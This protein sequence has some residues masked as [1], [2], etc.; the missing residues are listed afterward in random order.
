[1]RRVRR[2]P[3]RR[4]TT[5]Q[6]RNNSG[7][8]LSRPEVCNAHPRGRMSLGRRPPAPAARKRVRGASR[9]VFHYFGATHPQT[10]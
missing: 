8:T 5:P 9:S 7:A 1:M 4:R 3:R 10:H 6:A 2:R